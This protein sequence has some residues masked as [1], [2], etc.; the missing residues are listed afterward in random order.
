MIRVTRL[1]NE[2]FMVN[3]DLIEYVE[4]TPHTVISMASGRRLV[5]S[6]TC[7][8]VKALVIAYKCQIF[9]VK[10]FEESER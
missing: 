4:E 7:E 1:N 5:V 9:G 8:E 3:S 10:L 2:Q 6:E